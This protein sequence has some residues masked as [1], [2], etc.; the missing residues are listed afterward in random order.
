MIEHIAYVPVINY[1]SDSKKVIHLYRL[2]V[3][4]GIADNIRNFDIRK[5]QTRNTV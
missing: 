4:T 5:N 2:S 3:Q 1:Y